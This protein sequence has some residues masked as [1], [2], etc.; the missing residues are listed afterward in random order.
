MTDTQ[1][2]VSSWE[3][4]LLQTGAPPGHSV[5]MSDAGLSTVKDGA[6]SLSR[7]PP[8]SKMN[9]FKQSDLNFFMSY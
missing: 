2:S 8:L 6:H 5:T 3:H 7:A 9:I 4:F 1:K